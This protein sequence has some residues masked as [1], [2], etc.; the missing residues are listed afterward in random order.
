MN[1]TIPTTPKTLNLMV[2][3]NPGYLP[4]TDIYCLVHIFLKLSASFNIS[5]H[6]LFHPS[7]Y[8]RPF[9]HFR[10]FLIISDHFRCFPINS[11]NFQPLPI[12][13]A[14]FRSFPT[15]S[16]HFRCFSLISGNFRRF[17]IISDTSDHFWPFSH[18]RPILLPPDSSLCISLISVAIRKSY[19]WFFDYSDP[20]LTLLVCWFLD[21]TSSPIYNLLIVRVLSQYL[22]PFRQL[23]LF[24]LDMSAILVPPIFA[25]C[26]FDRTSDS[27]SGPVPISAFL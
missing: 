18:L 23:D 17:P 4:S 12:I 27:D 19:P 15:F 22:F 21:T 2:R 14:H 7:F 25:I 9:F 6:L 26:L 13:S 1:L 20:S 16:D 8:F 10:L 5:F 11:D 24:C 3:G